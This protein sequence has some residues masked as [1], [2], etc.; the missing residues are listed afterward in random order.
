MMEYG[1]GPYGKGPFGKVSSAI[2]ESEILPPDAKRAL[3]D[4][5]KETFGELWSSVQDIL[6]LVPPPELL[7]YWDTLLEIVRALLS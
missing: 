1:V 7:P 5:L 6:D 4:F 3:S 2:A